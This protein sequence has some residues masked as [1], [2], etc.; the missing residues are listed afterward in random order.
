MVCEFEFLI[1]LVLWRLAVDAGLL[2]PCVAFISFLILGQWDGL[3]F[4]G[5][6]MSAALYLSVTG[7]GCS[8]WLSTMQKYDT[9][10]FKASTISCAS[11]NGLLFCIITPWLP[12]LLL[13]VTHSCWMSL[14]TVHPMTVIHHQ[15]GLGLSV[16]LY[17][18]VNPYISLHNSMKPVF[19][20]LVAS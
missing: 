20:A 15:S 5:L 2:C 14:I 12:F 7:F 9:F 1:G 19:L 18:L 11:E 3:N 4:R 6:L 13:N 10:L 16:C 8:W 17:M